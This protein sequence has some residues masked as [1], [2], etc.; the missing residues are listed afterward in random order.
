MPIVQP[1]NEFRLLGSTRLN[2]YKD[3]MDFVNVQAQTDYFLSKSV[4]TF[5]DFQFIRKDT[6]VLVPRNYEVLRNCDYCMY[7]NNNFAQKWFYAF[8]TRIEYVNDSTSRIY[9]ETD[10]FQTWQFQIRYFKSF[11]ARSHQAQYGI[12]GKPLMNNL[13]PEQVEY[14][15][16]YVCKHTEVLTLGRYYALICSSAT[17]DVGDYGNVNDPKLTASTGGTFDGIPSV[18]DYYVCDNLDGGGST[19]SLYDILK[20]LSDFPWIT[21]CI[22]SVTVVPEE[23]LA[24]VG[25]TVTLPTG[26]T[27]GKLYDGYESSNILLDSIQNWWMHFGD[28]KNTK[29][30]TYPYS[31]IEMTCYNGNQF[32]IKPEAISDLAN[33]EV[34]LVNYIG[35]MPRLAYYIDNYNDLGDNGGGYSDRDTGAGEFLD[36]GVILG[37]FPQIPVAIDNYLL[38]MANNANSF[39]LANSLNN[40]NKKEAVTLG[41]IEGG[42]GVASNLMNLNVGGA[43]RSAYS[44]GKSAYM[45]VKNSEVAIRQQMAKI[46]D[47]EISPPTL[48]GQTGGDAFNIA[49]GIKGVTLKWKTIRPQYVSLLEEYFNRYGYLQNKIDVPRLTG[50]ES[51]NYIKTEGCTLGGNI[52]QEDMQVIKEMFDNGVTMWHNGTIGSYTDNKWTG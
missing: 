28:Y 24:T 27:I 31:F 40:Y 32:V 44:A 15:R 21:Q 42:M 5:T 1:Q 49:N 34:K 46:Q 26:Q 11:I 20:G 39:S 45:G 4:Q 48:S 8:V 35:A 47:A 13:L 2:G 38:Y 16:D 10:C 37:N 3:Q 52:P 25:H 9:I 50:N 19:S 18:L 51:L 17:L 29:L 30:Y 22:Q 14:G 41:A 12:N 43:V 36:A 7:K 33:L 6:S 23:V